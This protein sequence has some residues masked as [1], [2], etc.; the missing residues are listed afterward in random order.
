M[1][2]QNHYNDY[3]KPNDKLEVTHSLEK[4]L[5]RLVRVLKSVSEETFD[6]EI[7]SLILDFHNIDP[8]GQRFRYTITTKQ[9]KSFQEVQNFNIENIKERVRTIA[10]YFMGIDGYLSHYT[11][12]ANSLLSDYQNCN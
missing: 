4:L 3:S 12:L 11:D 2:N 1:K 5:N 9:E 8:D 7:K 10:N 6:E